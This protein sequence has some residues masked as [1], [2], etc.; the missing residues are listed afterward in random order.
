MGEAAAMAVARAAS[1][2]S[3]RTACLPSLAVRVVVL[4]W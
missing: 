3:A 2:L 1:L 4:M